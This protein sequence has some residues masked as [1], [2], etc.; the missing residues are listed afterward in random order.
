MRV[1]VIKD[2]F[3]MRIRRFKDTF[4]IFWDILCVCI[5]Q[6]VLIPNEKM[7][8]GKQAVIGNGTHGGQNRSHSVLAG[9][10]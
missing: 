3:K 4:G 1:H 7:T 6:C 8:M 9:V 10:E 2:N 5:F